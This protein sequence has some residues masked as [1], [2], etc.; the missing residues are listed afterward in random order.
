LAAL[1]R[2]GEPAS[3]G[4]V[5]RRLNETSKALSVYRDRL[6]NKGTLFID[7]NGL[8][9]FTVPGMAGYVLRQAGAEQPSVG[10]LV[11]QRRERWMVDKGSRSV[12]TLDGSDGHDGCRRAAIGPRQLPARSSSATR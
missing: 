6:L 1:L 10:E 9:R 2:A 8:L 5:A 4:A 11:P 7:D 12:D 3:G